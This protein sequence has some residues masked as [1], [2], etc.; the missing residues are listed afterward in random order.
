MA[1]LTHQRG[2]GVQSWEFEPIL[3]P[4]LLCWVEDGAGDAPEGS[5]FD[6]KG[7]RAVPSL[8][9]VHIGAGKGDQLGDRDRQVTGSCP[10]Q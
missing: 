7:G 2:S 6:G 9:P 1:V 10:A 8:P 5:S 3:V 4:L